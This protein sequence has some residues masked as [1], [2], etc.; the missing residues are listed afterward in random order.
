M[1]AM[2]LLMP[3]APKRNDLVAKIDADVLKK[4]KLVAAHRSITLAEYLSEMLRPLVDRD[5]ARLARDLTKK[6]D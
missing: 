3:R 1:S 4:A 6:S 2:G 5:V